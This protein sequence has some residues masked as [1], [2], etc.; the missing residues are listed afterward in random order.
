MISKK[1]A[2]KVGNLVGQVVNDG[3]SLIYKGFRGLANLPFFKLP[4]VN[5]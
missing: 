3:T 5:E 1:M 2:F 4:L